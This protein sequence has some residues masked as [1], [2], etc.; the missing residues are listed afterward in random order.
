MVDLDAAGVEL[1][2]VFEEEEDSGDFDSVLD[3]VLASEELAAGE[4]LDPDPFEP[5]P[6]ALDSLEPAPFLRP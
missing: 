3:D 6:L 5:E 2:S 4:P 1:A